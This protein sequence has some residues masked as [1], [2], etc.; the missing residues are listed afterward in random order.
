MHPT[1]YSLRF[2]R[3]CGRNANGGGNGRFIP[4]KRHRFSHHPGQFLV[5]TT[6]LPPIPRRD[7]ANDRKLF[8]RWGY[9]QNRIIGAGAAAN[10]EPL[11]I[12]HDAG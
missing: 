12:D 1:P 4:H 10:I 3:R 5:D 2:R 8:P 11:Y 6:H 7:A 9:Q